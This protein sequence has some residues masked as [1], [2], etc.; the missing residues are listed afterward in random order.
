MAPNKSIPLLV[1]LAVLFLAGSQSMYTVDQTE[2]GIV[3]QLGKP[4]GGVKG[5][6]LHLKVPFI[7]NVIFFDARVLEYDARPEEILTSDK[8]AMLVD[9]YT[10]WRIVDPL[11]FYRTLRTVINAQSRLDDIIYSQLRVALG[12]YTLVDVV[13]DK[14]AQIMREVTARS[15]ELIGEYGIEVVDVRIKRTDL[16]PENER[17]IFGRM[18][19]ERERQAKQYRSEGTEESAKVKSAADRERAVILADAERE[20][21]VL[22]GE[23]EA[24]ATRIFAESLKRSP[25]F[26]AFKRSLDAY[27]K[28]FKDNTRVLLTPKS[29]FLEFMR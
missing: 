19:A 5:P 7:Q 2:M 11:Q 25:E 13:A 23:G 20:A 12:R 16:P 27:E 14:R 9:N 4:V 21:Q 26:F 28:S 1:L 8:K 29:E 3:L 10:K 17:A 6:G 22:R 15:S 24:E 18:R